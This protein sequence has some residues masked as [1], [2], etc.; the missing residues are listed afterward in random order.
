MEKRDDGTRR[1]RVF[2]CDPMQS[3]QKG[4][5]ENMHRELRYI[6]CH[7]GKKP[8]AGKADSTTYFTIPLYCSQTLW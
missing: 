6:L 4:S 7:V 3:G 1:T 2:Y 5:L 8:I